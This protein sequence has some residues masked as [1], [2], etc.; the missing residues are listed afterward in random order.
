MGVVESVDGEHV[1]VHITQSSAC[2]TCKAAK[3]CHASES[4]EKDVDVY[5]ADASEYNKGESVVVV[6]SYGVGMFAVTL[7]MVVPMFIM[8]A[9]IVLL[10]ALNCSE[11][12][13]ATASVA[14]LIPYYLILFL[15]RKTINRKVTF[16][17]EKLKK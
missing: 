3:A 13:V 12:V 15:M 5:V 6:A 7:G 8:I 10:S 9:V 4:K 17:L 14:T 2:A 16:G 1:R 11:V